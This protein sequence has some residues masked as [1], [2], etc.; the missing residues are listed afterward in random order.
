MNVEC[1]ACGWN[2]SVCDLHHIIPKSKGGTN[3]H[4]NLTVL[5][6][7]CHRL[8]HDNKIT[9]FVSL[10]EHVGNRWREYYAKS[11]IKS[12]EVAKKGN[13]V[14]LEKRKKKAEEKAQKLIE[15]IKTSGIDFSKYGWVEKV[16][17]HFGIQ[18]QH[19]SRLIKRY[20]QKFYETCYKRMGN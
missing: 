8:A 17:N 19:V 7:N 11:N 6:P 9:K 18:H 14:S 15:E 3:D 12:I 4:T 2:E 16:S 13:I 20:D 5:C 1:S 10:E